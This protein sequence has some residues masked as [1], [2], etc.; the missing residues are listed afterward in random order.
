MSVEDS[1]SRRFELNIRLSY[2]QADYYADPTPSFRFWSGRKNKYKLCKSKQ[3]SCAEMVL[4]SF[5]FLLVRVIQQLRFGLRIFEPTSTTGAM[6]G[7]AP[8]ALRSALDSSIY[9]QTLI[10]P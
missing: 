8:S 3:A 1:E 9:V 5:G 4:G 6:S 2:F 10:W 7:A